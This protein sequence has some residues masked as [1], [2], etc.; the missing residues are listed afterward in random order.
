MSAFIH[1]VRPDSIEIVSDGALYDTAGRLRGVKRKAIALP[2][3]PAAIFGRGADAIVGTLSHMIAI[4][5]PMF[6]LAGKSNTFDDLVKRVERDIAPKIKAKIE[7][8]GGIPAE[9]QSE[10]VVAGFSE[11][12]GPT[13]AVMRTFDVSYDH[14]EEGIEHLAAWKLYTLPAY[15]AAGPDISADIEAMGLS[16]E[17]L[18]R[19]GLRPHAVVLMD[20]M[21]KRKDVNP[22]VAGDTP[23]HGVGGHVQYVEITRDDARSEIIHDWHDPIGEVIDPFRTAA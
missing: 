10:I 21:R 2:E 19:D 18:C 6:D 13:V 12:I 5:S 11:K 1:L 20:A 3:I 15:W 8:A 14:G 17:D 22:L 16:W 9:A 4:T 23:M 7:E